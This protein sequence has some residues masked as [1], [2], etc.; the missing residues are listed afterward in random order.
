MSRILLL[1]ALLSLP[2]VP[3]LAQPPEPGDR[4]VV[5]KLTAQP[6]ELRAGA[7]VTVTGSGCTPG[8]QVRFELYNPQLQASADGAVRGDGTFV[9]SINLPPSTKVGRSWLRAACLTPESEQKVM[10]AVLLVNR[11]E[12]VVTWTN[13]LFGVGAA[14]VTLGIG[15]GMLRQPSRPEDSSSGR[16]REPRRRKKR[17]RRRGT[18]SSATAPR[19]IGGVSIEPKTGAEL[20]G[21]K[22]VERTLEVD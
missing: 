8:G 11:P 4:T 6:K 12:F 7:D 18:T 22:D 13:V 2:A 3:A 5:G 14:L 19:T 21:G 15:L 9:Q 1:L 16:H 10:E 17:R 20:N